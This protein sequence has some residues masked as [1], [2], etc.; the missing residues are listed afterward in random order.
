MNTN[1][2]QSSGKSFGTAAF[3]PAI[4]AI[5]M[6]TAPATEAKPSSFLGQSAVRSLPSGL[7]RRS[8]KTELV[9]ESSFSRSMASLV[10]EFVASIEVQERKT[11]QKE[12]VIG[13]LRRWSLL[14]ANWDLE[15]AS[16]PFQSS[17]R[18]AVSF[19]RLIPRDQCLPEPQLTASGRASLFWDE[20]SLYAD[21]E[22]LGDNRI[23]YYIEK[24]GDK[25][26]GVQ[27]FDGQVIPAVF[28]TLLFA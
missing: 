18:Q 28:H 7:I 11:T 12:V 23:A 5:S 25:H 22:F 1:L 8:V 19:V 3:A 17:L 27:A 15:G 6:L 20:E 2:L 24:E 16:A 4:F 14:K 21:L 13:E 10:E 9:I 26:K